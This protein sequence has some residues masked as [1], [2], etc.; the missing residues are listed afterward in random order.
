MGD[1]S[2]YCG[3]DASLEYVNNM[4]NVLTSTPIEIG[5]NA[6]LSFWCRYEYTTYGSDGLYIDVSDGSGWETL[7]YLGGGGALNPL[8]IGNDW[9]E[10][11][12]ALSGYPAGTSI[13]V[14]F[15]FVSD[16]ADVAEGVYID[17]VTITGTEWPDGLGRPIPTMSQWCVAIMA[18][19]LAATG[20]VC[21]RRR[22]EGLS[23]PVG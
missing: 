15:R 2:W 3:V 7:D 16:E 20:A 21:L 17:D 13:T 4:D 22:R 11:T 8:N 23:S 18:L 9:L 14:R 5:Q 6:T 1:N 10:Y 19:L 12:Y